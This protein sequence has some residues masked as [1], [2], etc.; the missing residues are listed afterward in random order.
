MN[1]IAAASLLALALA[2][3]P[4]H[5]GTPSLPQG[6]D[7]L[8][9][10]ERVGLLAPQIAQ[11]KKLDVANQREQIQLQAKLRLAQLDLQEAIDADPPMSEDKVA[12]I[13]VRL[14]N[15]ETEIKKTQ[16]VMMLRVRATM[17]RAQWDKLQALRAEQ[18]AKA[19]QKPAGK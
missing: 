7:L 2:A 6:A 10:A 1:R 3:A 11:I 19:Q 15:A 5:A 14:G 9:V 17:N 13:V 8:Q 18:V 4:A 12:A 16:I